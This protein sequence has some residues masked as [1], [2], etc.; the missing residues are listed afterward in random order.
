[1]KITNRH[2]IFIELL[3]IPAAAASLFPKTI[4]RL[5]CYK[6]NRRW[7]HFKKP[8]DLRDLFL[9]QAL[10][11]SA[12]EQ[13]HFG[14]LADKF[15]VRQF[16]KERVGEKYLTKI[17]GNWTNAGDIDFET[18][19]IP[20]VLKTNN[21]CDTNIILR[22]TDDIDAPTL[23]RRLNSW[24]HYPYGQ[25]T[26]QPH[27]SKIKPIIFAEEYLEQKAGST[28]LPYDYK[29]FCFNGKPEFILFYSGRKLNGHIAQNQVFT[30]NWKPIEGILNM[31]SDYVL[32]RPEN[33]DEMLHVA[34]ELSRGFKAVRVDL[35]SIGHRVV[36]GEIT[37]TPDVI[38]YFTQE[39]LTDTMSKIQ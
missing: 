36:F 11:C 10:C 13:A 17:Y 23:R 18:L 27:Y 33:L 12:K 9:G 1:M 7:P 28:E 19:P 3:R 15:A 5:R 14:T 6:Q 16:V 21:A 2:P 20:C 24:L 31:P 32:P 34:T 25:L 29:I 30:P 8:R 26:G 4:M 37:F 38:L 35:Y 22:S 39:F